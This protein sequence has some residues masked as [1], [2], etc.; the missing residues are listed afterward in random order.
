VLVVVFVDALVEVDDEAGFDAADEA[1]VDAVDE[2]GVD[3]VDRVGGVA[4]GVTAT[5]EV[6]GLPDSPAGVT[7]SA[8]DSVPDDAAGSL[9]DSTVTST[10]LDDASLDSAGAKDDDEG[11]G[12]LFSALCCALV[13][14]TTPTST[15]MVSEKTIAASATAIRWVM[16]PPRPARDGCGPRSSIPGFPA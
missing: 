9:E 11:F 1:G 5:I 14:T 12:P 13:C 15:P 3:A 4:E 16:S 8:P 2:A 6:A 10:E 7:G